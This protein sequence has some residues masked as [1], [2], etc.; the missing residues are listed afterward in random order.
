MKRIEAIEKIMSTVTDEIVIS[1]TGMISREL[2]QVKDRDKNFYML[3]SM[4]N[5]LGIGLGIAMNSNYN[6]IVI[7]GDGDTLMSLGTLVLHK[8][9]NLKNLKHYILDNN[10][11][12]STGGQ[13]TCS[14]AI[15][16][17][18]ITQ[19]TEVIKVSGEKGDAPRIP[20]SPQQIKTRFK[21]A[22]SIN[23]SQ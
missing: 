21:S 7:S 1:S 19:N 18:K 2:Y 10:C 23:S 13:Q 16:F 8:K 3:G 5:S 9:L 14:D 6:V 4:G 12:S 15:N 22:V 17:L 20:L 11:L